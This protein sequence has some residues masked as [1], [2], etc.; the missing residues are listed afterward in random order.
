VNHASPDLVA[1]ILTSGRRLVVAVTGGG[2]GAI[3]ALVETPGASQSVL[4][5]IVPYSQAALADWLGGAPDQ[6]CSAPTARAMAMAAFLRARRLDAG[7]DAR[8]LVGV[9]ATASLASNRPKRGDHRLHVAVQTAER[10]LS[11]SYRFDKKRGDRQAEEALAA[12]LILAALAEACELSAGDAAATAS[13]LIEQ[14]TAE[15][16][17]AGAELSELLL[18]ARGVVMLPPEGRAATEA[19]ARP[20]DAAARAIFP[21]AFNPPHAGH[22]RMAELAEARLGRPIAWEVSIAN[23]DKSPLDFIAVRDRVAGLRRASASRA[24]ALTRAATFRE[25]AEL[26]PGATFVVGADTLARIAE[27]RYYGGDAAQRDAAAAAIVE[28]G[29][30]FL[31]FGREIDGRFHGL[32]GLTLP[33]ALRAACDAVPAESFRADVSSSD[34]RRQHADDAEE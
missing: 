7:A 33:E 19:T 14:Q 16:E 20:G 15:D 22:L 34:I 3:G 17:R 21:G 11:R 10:T 2:S 1:A 13:A 6:A 31:V 29:N 28:R 32:E 26:F 30:R 9:G 5:A 24:I 27:P 12:R 18:G 23:V 25:K 8:M 4:E